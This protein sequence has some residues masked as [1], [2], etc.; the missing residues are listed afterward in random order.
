M[1]SL[2]KDNFDEVVG[3]GVTLV[4]FWAEWCNPCK[5]MAPILEMLSNEVDVNIVSVDVE[6]QKE[7]TNKFCIQSL[8]TFLVFKDGK[9]INR[10]IGVKNKNELKDIITA[11]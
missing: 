9:E 2:T 5:M 7:L 3:N 1:E 4:D 11:A 10:M 8:P 6:A